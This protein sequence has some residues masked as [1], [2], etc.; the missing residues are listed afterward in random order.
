MPVHRIENL[1]M[2][3]QEGF[4]ENMMQLKIDQALETRLTE[5]GEP[6]QQFYQ[7]L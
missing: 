3:L 7:K 4:L 1:E 2:K 5:L 6:D